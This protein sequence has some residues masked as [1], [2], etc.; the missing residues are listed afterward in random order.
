MLKEKL[1][2]MEHPLSNALECFEELKR[3]YPA[4]EVFFNKNKEDILFLMEDIQS[5]SRLKDPTGQV[6]VYAIGAR[7]SYE[8]PSSSFSSAEDVLIELLDAK[9]DI[10]RGVRKVFEDLES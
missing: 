2:T 10:L 8:Y 5:E 9:R 7:L 4:F 1:N 3:E 6:E